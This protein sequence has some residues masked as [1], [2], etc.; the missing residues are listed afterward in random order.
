MGLLVF[1]LVVRVVFAGTVVR[2][3]CDVRSFRLVLVNNKRVEHNIVN[4]NIFRGGRRS[5]LLVFR[6]AER[7]VAIETDANRLG[8]LL[9][10]QKLFRRTRTANDATAVTT[11]VLE[12]FDERIGVNIEF[13]IYIYIYNVHETY[14]P[15]E[16]CELGLF[17][18]HANVRFVVRNPNGRMMFDGFL[19]TWKHG[20]F[21]W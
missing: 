11:M 16:H 2:A 7:V 3:G 18:V 14:P 17:A 15:Y 5:H 10:E 8:G 9:R 4:K 20:I 1:L 21:Q 12:G 19:A 6:L 13:E